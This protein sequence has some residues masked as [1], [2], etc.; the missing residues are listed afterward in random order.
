MASKCNY[1]MPALA[2][3]CDMFF[4]K[5]KHVRKESRYF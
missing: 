3:L 2:E 1:N 4:F 5:Y